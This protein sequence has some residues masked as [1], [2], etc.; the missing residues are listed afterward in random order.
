MTVHGLS[1]IEIV[2]M[3]TNLK[4]KN[5]DL[6]KSYCKTKTIYCILTKLVLVICQDLCQIY[7]QK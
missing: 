2:E 6:N 4:P 1:Y 7:E 3:L 5:T